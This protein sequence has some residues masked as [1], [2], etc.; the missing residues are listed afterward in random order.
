VRTQRPARERLG[1]LAPGL[2][3]LVA[4]SGCGG[5]G[6]GIGGPGST[7]APT[8]SSVPVEPRGCDLGDLLGD[9][10]VQAGAGEETGSAPDDPANDTEPCSDVPAA[11]AG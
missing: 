7:D 10:D 2:V 11:P 8:E 9:D 3:V 4:L 5:A 6:D 1:R